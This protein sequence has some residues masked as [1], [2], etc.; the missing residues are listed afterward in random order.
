[1]KS[2]FHS[3][4]TFFREVGQEARKVSWPTWEDTKQSTLLVVVFSAS[5][6]V[7]LGL[8]DVIFRAFIV[9]FFI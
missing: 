6:A 4:Q 8:F 1:M 5:V 7:I 3:I 2:I 9:R